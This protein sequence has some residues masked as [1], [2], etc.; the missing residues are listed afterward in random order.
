MAL[1]ATLALMVSGGLAPRANAF[2]YW[3]QRNAVGRANLDGSNVDQSFIT[4]ADTPDAVAVDGQHL[5]W[6][7]T[8]TGAIGRAGLDSS[9]VDQN[10][11]NGA[12][13][14][15]GLAVDALPLA[16]QV[17][18]T[19]PARGPSCSPCSATTSFRGP[20]RAS[21]SAP[22]LKRPDSRLT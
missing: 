11:I 19:T 3:S 10:F 8:A 16:P 18:I 15:L 17:S 13:N 14:P 9:N 21:R 7:N 4:G 6:A 20:T 5:Y 1:A 22:P 2:V 12:E